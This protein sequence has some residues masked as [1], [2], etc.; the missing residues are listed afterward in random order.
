MITFLNIYIGFSLLTYATV[1][2]TWYTINAN[3]LREHPELERK[4]IGGLETILQYIK[5]LIM[6]FVPLLN[7]CMFFAFL[8]GSEQIEKRALDRISKDGE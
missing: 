2:M 7:L 1:L 6:C 5:I 3:I 4:R 8:M